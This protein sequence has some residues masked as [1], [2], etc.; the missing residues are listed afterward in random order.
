ML[1][2]AAIEQLG[3]TLGLSNP[4]DGGALARI[5]LPRKQA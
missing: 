4:D 2:R 3:G 1:T 5:E